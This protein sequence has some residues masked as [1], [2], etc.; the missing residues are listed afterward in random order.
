M[1]AVCGYTF[2]Y[3]GSQNFPPKKKKRNLQPLVAP[4]PSVRV[5]VCFCLCVPG[6]AGL[7]APFRR[8][9][10]R[11]RLFYR[12]TDS[13]RRRCA[14]DSDSRAV[15]VP[16]NRPCNHP[17]RPRVRLLKGTTT[18]LPHL[19]LVQG[20]NK[21]ERTRPIP[22]SDRAHRTTHGNEPRTSARQR[23]RERDRERERARA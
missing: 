15:A 7:H 22:C 5:S 10:L 13:V 2:A 11:T 19:P 14:P 3:F 9:P 18:L 16:S 1:V 4:L 20:S 21:K 17:A 8:L 6:V 12:L 23:S